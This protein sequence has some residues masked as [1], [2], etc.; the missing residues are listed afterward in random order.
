MTA[1]GRNPND[2][3]FELEF[4]RYHEILVKQKGFIIV[5]CLSAVLS[6]LALTYVF[7]E[8]YVAATNI[9]YRP[10]ERSLLRQKD[11]EAFG[12]P[13]PA[14]P[15]K[16]IIQSLQDITRSEVIL[17]PVVEEL[18]LD[19]PIVVEHPPGLRGL[20][21]RAKDFAKGLMSDIRNLAKYGRIIEEDP[22]VLAIKGLG[23]NISLST[24][25]DSY[26]YVLSVKDKYPQR[27]AMI[28]DTAGRYLVEWLR[29]QDQNP[30]EMRYVQLQA[31]L[32]EKEVEIK[33][34][35]DERQ[36]LLEDNDYVAVDEEM[37]DGVKSLYAMEQDVVELDAE[38]EEKHKKLEELDERIRAQKSAEAQIDPKDVKRL[39]SE[40]LF[41]EIELEGLMAKRG[42]QRA[43][44][45]RLRIR[46]QNLLALQK[47]VDNL[48]MQIEAT[49]R[50]HLHLKDL[51]VEALS[52]A[53]SGESEIKVLHAAHVSARPVQPIKVYHVALSAL[54]SL[55]LSTGLIYVLAF[56][57]I[58]TFFSSDG[59]KGRRPGGGS[60]NKEHAESA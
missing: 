52:Q 46:L 45:T 54:L 27:A 13:A 17:R 35:R 48:D 1:K 7:S 59:V 47:Q 49:T 8:R 26:I 16:V 12:A 4:S 50:D 11:T 28:V 53:N 2:F 10:L 29:E 58:R 23:N 30:A 15:F 41:L 43:S 24:T 40:R 32:D 31:Q 5:F 44:L 20:Y 25:K 57:N 6:S 36:A 3:R 33:K 38:I 39:E 51:Y 18:G 19:V 42:V 34:F 55:F 56:F 37:A 60:E 14:A 21:P 22:T 9:Y